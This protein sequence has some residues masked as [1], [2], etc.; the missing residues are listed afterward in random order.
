MVILNK[1][2]SLPDEVG[3]QRRQLRRRLIPEVHRRQQPAQSGAVRRQ[4]R[5]E[6][7]AVH[8]ERKEQL[9]PEQRLEGSTVAGEHLSDA[10]GQQVHEVAVGEARSERPRRLH[11]VQAPV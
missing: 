3:V 9:L 5:D 10:A 8:A 2:L 1:T 11:V 7:G 6:Y 4:F